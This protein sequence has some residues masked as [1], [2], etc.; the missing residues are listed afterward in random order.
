MSGPLFPQGSPEALQLQAAIAQRLGE[1]GLDN[2]TLAEFIAV[3]ILNRKGRA[4]VAEE[5]LSIVGD[6]LPSSFVD[7][8]FDTL[9]SDGQ[10]VQPVAE[11]AS[12]EMIADSE[13]PFAEAGLDPDAAEFA[14]EEQGEEVLA[15]VQLSS[16]TPYR[17]LDKA[18]SEATRDT[19]ARSTRSVP[20]SVSD[21]PG[22]ERK[23]AASEKSTTTFTVS[24]AGENPIERTEEKP[25]RC[26]FWPNCTK[27]SL[28]CPFHHP[29]EVRSPL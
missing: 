24:L 2:D 5:L 4:Q 8:I 9:L 14:P 29:S 22:T 3:M 19:T 27:G 21:R 18:L 6:E 28:E 13:E 15:E 10:L 12:D 26:R 7:W 17:L 23:K 20:Y 16:K 25:I 1:A 11:V